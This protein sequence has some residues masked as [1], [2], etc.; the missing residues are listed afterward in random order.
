MPD[1]D[2]FHEGLER[3]YQQI[4]RQVM[5]AHHSAQQLAYN[6]MTP[7]KKNLAAYGNDIVALLVQEAGRLERMF[8]PLFMSTIDW[9][10]HQQHVERELRRLYSDVRGK[11]IATGAFDRH[12]GRILS[13]RYVEDHKV[14]LIKEYF[15]GVWNADWEAI[16]KIP[17]QKGDLDTHYNVIVPLI[18]EMRPCAEEFIEHFVEQ[19]ARTQDVTNLRMPPNPNLHIPVTLNE[20]LGRGK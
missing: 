17:P 15:L 10:D 14:A 6:A 13:G 12:L 11:N 9:D 3:R 5:Q 7:F 18:E 1:G 19:A 8:D 16:A 2:K 4:F 20:K